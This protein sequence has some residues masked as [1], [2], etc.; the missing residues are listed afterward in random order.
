MFPL[1][2]IADIQKHPEKYKLIQEVPFLSI[3]EFPHSLYPMVGDEVNVSVID[4]ETTGLAKEDEIIEFGWVKC[5]YSPSIDKITTL[6]S[7]GSMYQQPS[8]PIPRIISQITGIDD[9][10]VKGHSFDLSVIADVLLEDEPLVLAHNKSFDARFVEQTFGHNV[11][12]GKSIK[13]GC[14]INDMNWQECG[15]GSNKLELLLLQSNYFYP[16]HRASIDCLALAF[17]LSNTP[18]ALKRIIERVNTQFYNV[19]AIGS[20]YDS[21][22]ALKANGFKWNGENKVWEKKVAESE[23]ESVKST[24]SLIYSLGGE[25]ARITPM[26]IATEY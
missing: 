4:T 15:F 13:W 18:N 23:L 19:A 10:M 1:K 22:D 14:T 5:L 12:F 21:K 9:D 7:M 3:N 26:S 8:R 2:K 25:Q 17:L 20:P 24:L 16:A 11:L 6:V